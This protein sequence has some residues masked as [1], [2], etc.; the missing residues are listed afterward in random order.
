MKPRDATPMMVNVVRRSVLLS[1]ETIEP[2][3]L[4]LHAPPSSAAAVNAPVALAAG[5]GPAA[6]A[7]EAGLPLR[8]VATRAAE[9]AERWAIR[10]ALQTAHGNKSEAARLLHTDFK[11]L[12]GKMRRYG[13]D[14]RGQPET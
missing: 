12:H 10:Q 13:I 2:D 4:G 8:D 14:A 5:H 3:A 11:T 6:V 9:A 1:A 7:P